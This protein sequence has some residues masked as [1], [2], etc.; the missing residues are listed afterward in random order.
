[1]AAYIAACNASGMN[2]RAYWLEYDIKP[3]NYYYWL[4]KGGEPAKT[5]KFIIIPAAVTKVTVYIAFTNGTRV[6]FEN[7]PP[8]DYV[9]KLVS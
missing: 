6:C 2:V 7:M 8:A 5:G 1:M 4:S 3:S 9:K